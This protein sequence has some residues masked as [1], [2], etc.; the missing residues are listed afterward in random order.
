MIWPRGLE[1]I[2]V[3]TNK[4]KTSKE[5]LLILKEEHGRGLVLRPGTMCSAKLVYDDIEM[6]RLPFFNNG[7]VKNG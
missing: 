4:K 2:C 1:A 5:A 6:E 3:G 7:K